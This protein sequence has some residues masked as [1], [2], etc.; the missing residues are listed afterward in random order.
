MNRK[1]PEQE[2]WNPALGWDGTRFAYINP[3]FL[4]EE[5]EKLRRMSC[6]DAADYL[7]FD[8]A[9]S[10]ALND[11]GWEKKHNDS[12]TTYVRKQH[13][14][15]YYRKYGRHVNDYEEEKLEISSN[16]RKAKYSRTISATVQYDDGTAE[17]TGPS[18]ETAYGED[19]INE[20]T[21]GLWD[22]IVQKKAQAR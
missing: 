10:L 8:S 20:A 17:L 4:K 3:E 2:E 14:S 19:A 18:I 7:M 21:E 15:K 1:N 11:R 16:G 22:A 6:G 9:W 5:R 12:L 13:N